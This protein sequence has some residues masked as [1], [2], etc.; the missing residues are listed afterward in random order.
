[1]LRDK[2]R[3]RWPLIP[4]VYDRETFLGWVKT[5]K[6]K[7]ERAKR[8][9][10]VISTLAKMADGGNPRAETILCAAGKKFLGWENKPT[11]AQRA[12]ARQ[13]FGTFLAAEAITRALRQHMKHG[14][15]VDKR[16]LKIVTQKGKVF[17]EFDV[18]GTGK[19]V[20]RIATGASFGDQLPG[21]IGK[22]FGTY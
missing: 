1:D 12:Q 11:K 2:E 7:Y 19:A 17:V 4:D 9:A 15:K 5:A 3:S 22:A 21:L 16:S 13:M 20:R 14:G 6:A 18:D 8:I 10:R